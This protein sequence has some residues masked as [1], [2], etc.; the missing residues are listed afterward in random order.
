M[1]KILKNISCPFLALLTFCW[2]VIEFILDYLCGFSPFEGSICAALIMISLCLI[3]AVIITFLRNVEYPEEFKIFLD[4]VLKYIR[5]RKG[6]PNFLNRK[7]DDILKEFNSSMLNVV[8]GDFITKGEDIL[9][10]SLELYAETTQTI[11]AV[12]FVD[13][14]RYWLDNRMGEKSD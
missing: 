10:Y 14:R 12:S 13:M 8:K 6:K 11:Q 7:F 5:M 3:I 1:F 4:K 9:Q 2:L